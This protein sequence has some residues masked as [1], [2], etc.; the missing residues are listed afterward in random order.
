MNELKS[1]GLDRNT[2]GIFIADNGRCNLRGKGYLY[3]SGIHIP[4]IV[5]APGR[6]QHGTVVDDLV[7]TTDI[8]ASILK[9][10][11]AEIP[12]YMTAKPFIGEAVATG[13]V[14]VRSARDIWDEIDECSRSITTRQYTYI[15]NYMPEVPWATDQAYLELNRPALWVMRR[16]KAEGKLSPNEMLFFQNSKPPE[17]LYDLAKDPDQ[18]HNLADNPEYASVLEQMRG[19]ETLWEAGNK[20]CGLEDL[21]KRVPEKGLAA[22]KARTWA[23]IHRPEQWERLESGELMATS[24][25]MQKAKKS[26]K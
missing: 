9:L 1:K 16:L 17:E 5:W 23:K 24:H 25:W 13:R 20:D 10:A 15:K 21:G 26:K 14:F 2:A 11:G 7:L 6:I 22:V 8:S 3:E 12:D 19:Q 4:M 18:L